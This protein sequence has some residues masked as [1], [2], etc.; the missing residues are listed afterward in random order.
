LWLDQGH[1]YKFITSDGTVSN[2]ARLDVEAGALSS[3]NNLDFDGSAETDGSF[4]VKAGRGDNTIVGGAGNDL[5]DF[6]TH[7]DAGDFF[8]GRAGSDTVLIDK[9]NAASITLS[10]LRNIEFLDL[11]DDSYHVT[12][13]DG[14]VASGAQLFVEFGG[15]GD[16]TL[17]FDGSA[18]TDGSFGLGGGDARDHL[19]GGARG[20]GLGGGGGADFLRGGGGDDNYFYHSVSDSTG[21]RFDMIYGFNA[22]DADLLALRNDPISGIDGKIAHGTLSNATFDTDLAAAANAGRLLAHHAVLF[23]PD[24]GSHAGQTFLVI[25]A[26]A[27]AGYQA[28]ADYVIR[29]EHAD[30]IGQLSTASF[31]TF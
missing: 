18:E 28:G 27:H 29:L 13:T 23:T 12:G 19:R 14:L 21:E 15:T 30:N 26:N 25:D 22:D 8:N 3:A 5:V 1:S 11:K 9:A 10:N 17:W 31:S 6:G 20:D 16:Q 2:G 7:F 24:A 4:D